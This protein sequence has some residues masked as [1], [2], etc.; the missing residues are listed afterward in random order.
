MELTAESLVAGSSAAKRAWE[1]RTPGSVPAAALWLTKDVPLPRFPH[2]SSESHCWKVGWGDA[3]SLRTCP[4]PQGLDREEGTSPWLSW[5][6]VQTCSRC[7]LGHLQ[8]TAA[9]RG[10]T[11]PPSSRGPPGGLRQAGRKVETQF[12]HRYSSGMSA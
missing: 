1:A 4:C 8:L 12:R 6:S 3:S 7:G 5:S 9:C 10:L 11:L 2:L